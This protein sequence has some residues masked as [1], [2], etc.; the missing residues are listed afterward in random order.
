MLSVSWVGKQDIEMLCCPLSMFET[1]MTKEPLNH[2]FSDTGVSVVMQ[3]ML[4][5][6]GRKS[7]YLRNLLYCISKK[8]LAQKLT[9][10]TAFQRLAGPRGTVLAGYARGEE[11]IR[12]H[13]I[14]L[15]SEQILSLYAFKLILAIS[16]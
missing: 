7:T 12:N 13:K 3:L 11:V 9:S 1:W 5:I 10:S 4:I 16:R 8:L 2:H 15:V 6:V 14:R